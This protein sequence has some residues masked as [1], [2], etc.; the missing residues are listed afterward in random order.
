MHKKKVSVIIPVYNEEHSIEAALES[1]LR[2]DYPPHL[3]EILVIDGRSTDA[4]VE[5]VRRVAR[6]SAVNIKII[7]NP[8]RITPVAL[9]LGIRHA[10][11]ELII[12]ADAHTVYPPGY[13]EELVK[14]KERLKADNVGGVFVHTARKN[15]KVNHAIVAVLDSPFGVGGATYRL[16]RSGEPVETDTVPFGIWDKS[17]FDRIGPFDPRLVRNQ[18]IELNKRIIAHG[19]KI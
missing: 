11:G 1:L 4:T 5:I 15:I 19:G 17:L 3:L 8:Q 6:R 9:N 14:W 10:T 2:T 7:D 12:R 18:D 13:I 16:V